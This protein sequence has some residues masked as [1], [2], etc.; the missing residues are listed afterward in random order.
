[1]TSKVLAYA[2]V[3]VAGMAA[4]V[5]L[6]MLDAHVARTNYAEYMQLSLEN[7]NAA[8]D[9]LRAQGYRAIVLDYE[10]DPTD[11]ECAGEDGCYWY[12]A[13]SPEGRYAEGV[14]RAGKKT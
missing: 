10:I 9:K 4:A 5:G 13:L 3:F 2:A 8:R 11:A 1:M 6:L 14:V 12:K 7:E